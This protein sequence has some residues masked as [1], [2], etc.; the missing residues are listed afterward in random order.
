LP[1]LYPARRAVRNTQGVRRIERGQQRPSGTSV[2]G[3][4]VWS[5]TSVR[6]VIARSGRV[7]RR[8]WMI[9]LICGLLLALSSGLAV[10]T[11]WGG[12]RPV[13]DDTLVTELL[14]PPPARRPRPA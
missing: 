11:R 1:A 2:P 8:M 4:P 10:A 3:T 7:T 13:A 14:G 6:G 5:V 9:W 12:R